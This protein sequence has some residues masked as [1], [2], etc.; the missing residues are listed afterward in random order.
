MPYSRLTT[1]VTVPEQSNVY[2]M[3]I[4]FSTPVS[5]TNAS[6]TPP[7]ATP[8]AIPLPVVV[9]YAAAVLTGETNHLD[10]LAPSFTGSDGTIRKD[11]D[12]WLLE[13]PRF[14]S[15]TT[16]DQLFSLAEDILYDIECILA[17]YINASP[18]LSVQYVKFVTQEGAGFRQVRAT[19]DINVIST[20][21]I[22]E[23]KSLSGTQPLGSAV[24]RAINTNPRI[25]EAFSLHGEE[26]LSWSQIYDIIEFLR[27]EKGIVEAKLAS[28]ADVS[29]LQRT[30]TYYRHLGNPKEEVLPP[31][32]F[33]P[34]EGTE[35]IRNLLKRWIAQE[36]AK[37]Q[38]KGSVVDTAVA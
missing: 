27:G 11:G 20:K 2:G 5:A 25:K 6:S 23:L 9:S 30:A 19:A 38:E 35:F 4:S 14:Q 33:S 8:K 24:L 32:P 36:L 29:R 7:P 3:T 26:E 34:A 28:G 10:N 31:K 16:G 17:L 13:S 15:C 37:S 18:F 1:T 22:A 12:L 21:G